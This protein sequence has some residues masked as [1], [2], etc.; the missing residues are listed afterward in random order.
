MAFSGAW[1]HLTPA[2]IGPR[3]TGTQADVVERQITTI[4]PDNPHRIYD[5]GH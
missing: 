5:S 3:A 4:R 2:D 1:T